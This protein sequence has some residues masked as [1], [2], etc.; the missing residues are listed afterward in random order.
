MTTVVDRNG[1]PVKRRHAR[2]SSGDPCVPRAHPTAG[3]LRAA[4]DDG[5]RGV[6]GDEIDEAGGGACVEK[7]WYE[8]DGQR[9][10]IALSLEAHEMEVAS[11]TILPEGAGTAVTSS[12]GT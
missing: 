1:N 4:R 9:R 8:A 7:V 5:W 10:A 2:A 11:T 6:R 3:R 12:P